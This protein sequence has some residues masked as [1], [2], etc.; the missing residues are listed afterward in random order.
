[1][2]NVKIILVIA[3]VSIALLGCQQMFEF[4]LFSAVDHASI[5]SASELKSM[6]TSAALDLLGDESSSDKFYEDLANDPTKKQ[7]LEGYL[8]DIWAPGSSEAPEDQQRAALLYADIEMK[9]TGGDELVN[10]LVNT[11]LSDNPPNDFSDFWDQVVPAEAQS[12][13]GM[14][15]M[16]GGFLDAWNAYDAFGNTLSSND[17]P[18]GTNMGEVAQ[19]AVVS[20]YL[21]S[22][23]EANGVDTTS[24][25]AASD[26]YDL[27]TGTT[28]PTAT[29]I[30]DPTSST[31]LNNI[32]NTAGLTDLFNT[33]A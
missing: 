22:F 13:Q 29:A 16:L 18:E 7:E 14:E 4:N 27:L 2:R 1:M 3:A 21:Y 8:G 20:F 33:G 17:P 26:L 25:T 28:T 31:S 12:E 24:D 10:N 19:N 23:A 30:P 5:P 6:E 9:T 11:L 32:I 15:E